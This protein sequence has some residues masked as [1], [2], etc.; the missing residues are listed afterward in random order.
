MK[1]A[2]RELNNEEKSI[3]FDAM[4]FISTLNKKSNDRKICHIKNLATEMGYD[5]RKLRFKSTKKATEITKSLQSIDNIRL[6]RY[7]LREMILLSIADHELTDKEVDTIYDIAKKCCI[8]EDKIDDFFLWAA[9]GVEWQIE[10]Q[11]LVE[12]DL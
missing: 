8:S 1:V 2:K 9:K 7:I 10:G 4:C 11:K 5:A 12:E 6:R 3:F